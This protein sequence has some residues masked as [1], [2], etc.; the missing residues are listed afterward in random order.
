[1]LREL[2]YLTLF[3]I[4]LVLLCDTGFVLAETPKAP[5]NL[6]QA[7]EMGKDILWGLPKAIKK[8]WEQALS[9]WRKIGDWLWKWLNIIWQK[10][11]LFLGREVERK[12][13]EVKEELEKE[14]EEFKEEIKGGTKSLWQRFKELIF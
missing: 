3:L 13:P 7:E 2:K 8:P 5:E 6:E 12:K 14:K 4:A 9:V 1:M 11:S 10:I